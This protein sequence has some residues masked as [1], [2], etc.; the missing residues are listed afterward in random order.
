MAAPAPGALLTR[1]CSTAAAAI[2]SQ[3]TAA[4]GAAGRN[5]SSTGTSTASTAT[6]TRKPDGAMGL[7]AN[8][9]GAALAAGAVLAVVGL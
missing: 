6:T 8:I 2:I 4:L 3:A 7:S 9:A 5:A 1:T